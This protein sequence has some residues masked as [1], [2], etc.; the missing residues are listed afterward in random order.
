MINVCC[1]CLILLFVLILAY[2]INLMHHFYSTELFAL[3]AIFSFI[4]FFW[5]ILY[6]L[7][8]SICSSFGRQLCQNCGWAG[9]EPYVRSH[10]TESTCFIHSPIFFQTIMNFWKFSISSSFGRQLNEK[11]MNE[12]GRKMR[13]NAYYRASLLVHTPS[14]K[15]N[16]SIMS[17]VLGRR[18]YPFLSN[19]IVENSLYQDWN[20][21]SK[22]EWKSYWSILIFLY[23]G[24]VIALT[25]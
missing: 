24:L 3:E 10:I 1:C 8:F 15:T 11:N 7:V 4:Q 22:S 19:R 18:R 9:L 23:F 17:L 6:F 5:K 2:L 13:A 14:C 16:M 20:L 25:S 12:H 21:N